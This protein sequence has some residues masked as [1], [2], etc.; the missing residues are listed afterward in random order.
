MKFL[1]G[2][3]W[4]WLSLYD[5]V[6]AEAYRQRYLLGVIVREGDPPTSWPTIDSGLIPLKED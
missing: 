4:C 2:L 5:G 6:T 3:Y 1:H